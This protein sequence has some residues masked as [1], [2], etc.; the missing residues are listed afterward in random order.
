MQHWEFA[1]LTWGGGETQ[2]GFTHHESWRHQAGEEFWEIMRRLGDEG[3]ELVSTTQAAG[4]ES[5]LY[6]FKRPQT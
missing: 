3:W 6:W 4:G 2:V 1:M 5:S